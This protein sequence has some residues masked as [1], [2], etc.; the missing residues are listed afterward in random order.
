PP[1]SLCRQ[2]VALPQL[3]SKCRFLGIS[4]M[5]FPAIPLPSQQSVYPPAPDPDTLLHQTFPLHLHSVSL[6][7]ESH[8]H[9]S[10]RILLSLSNCQWLLKQP[11]LRSNERV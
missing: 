9:G 1:L 7:F 2:S 6:P 4:R 3:P 11:F 5:H 10:H 8:F